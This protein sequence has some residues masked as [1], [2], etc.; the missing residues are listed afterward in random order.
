MNDVQEVKNNL[1]SRYDLLGD[2]EKSNKLIIDWME[3][4]EEKV[5]MDTGPWVDD[6][7]A[8]IKENPDSKGQL[9]EMKTTLQKFRCY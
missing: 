4:T 5:K 7:D 9:G 3:D 1:N 8:N 2:L 6:T